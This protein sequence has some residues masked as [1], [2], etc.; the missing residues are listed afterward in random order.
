[1]PL[2][3]RCHCGA[4]RIQL[5][6]HPTDATS[7]NCS[8]CARTGARWAYY[9]PGELIFLSHEDERLYSTRPELQQHY[10]CGRCGMQTW[11]D[12]PDWSSLYNEDGTPKAGDGTAVP[13]ARKYGLNLNLVDDLDW[14]AITITAVDGRNSW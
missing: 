9:A 7:C 12:A 2:I 8:Y 3:A 6:A 5:P 13:T 4:T 1:M 14:S 11:G 10:F